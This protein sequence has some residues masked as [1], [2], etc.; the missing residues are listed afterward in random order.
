[1]K[2]AYEYNAQ[3]YRCRETEHGE[4]TSD[5]ERETAIETFKRAHRAKCGSSAA[6]L[7]GRSYRHGVAR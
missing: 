2:A 4:R 7:V 1:M 6:F 3:C 5:V